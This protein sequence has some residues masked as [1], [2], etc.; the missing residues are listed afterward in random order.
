MKI[1]LMPPSAGD[2]LAPANLAVVTA[3]ELV[4]DSP[5][6]ADAAAEELK[7]VARRKDQLDKQRKELT[8]PL[9]DLKKKI[10]DL[11]RPA[12]DRLGEAEGILKRSLLTWNDEQERIRRAE[13]ER[14]R[15][16]AEEE[17]KRLEEEA[18]AA[19]A[20]AE[21]AASSGDAAVVEQ[22]QQAAEHAEVMAAMVVAPAPVAVAKV[23][24]TSVRT[25]LDVEVTSL[26]D[27]AR[28]VAANPQLANLIEPNM[29][30][31]RAQA[32]V[33]GL[34]G[35]LPGVRIYSKQTLATS[36]R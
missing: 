36:R 13:E 30:A 6:M 34:Y 23:E 3:Q 9:D 11:F 27:L 15:L 19:R 8:G 5:E 33:L 28:F 31:I 12:I 29:T 7:A 14:R 32:R 21:A 2:L 26:I 4:I 16:A 35:N 24:G 22:A 20:L 1:E 10:M 17:R 18:A 25:T